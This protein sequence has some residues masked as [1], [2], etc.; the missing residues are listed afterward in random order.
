MRTQAWNTLRAGLVGLALLTIALHPVPAQAELVTNGGF[1]AEGAQVQLLPGW[2]VTPAD[3][4]LHRVSDYAWTGSYAAQFIGAAALS[5]SQTLATQAGQS[6]AYSFWVKS[7]ARQVSS[8]RGFF[9]ASADGMALM[10]PLYEPLPPVDPEGPF[11]GPFTQ[12]S[13][14]FTAVDA[15]TQLVFS[16]A[17]SVFYALDDASVVAQDAPEPGTIAML[18]LGL[19]RLVA[20]RR[21]MG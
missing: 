15:S 16:T 9:T 8:P 13:G 7:L 1:E 3:G 12:F 19:F 6:Y 18:G 4:T 17:G 21:R 20:M 14:M 2:T 5:L 11:D 10:A